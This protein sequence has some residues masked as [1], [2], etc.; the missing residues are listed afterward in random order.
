MTSALKFSCADFT[1]PLLSH[2]DALDLIAKLGIPA[3]D[4]GL[5]PERSHLQPKHFVGNVSAAAKRLKSKVH[6][7]GLQIV[8]LFAVP[9]SI[10]HELAPNHPEEKQR[11]EWRNFFQQVIDLAEE[12]GVRHVTTGPG[13][14]FDG[15]SIAESLKRASDEL[16]WCAE[17]AMKAGRQL[18]V[19]AH[20]WSVASTPLLARKLVEMTNH[21]TLTLDYGHFT[22]Q[23]FSDDEIE[24][25]VAYASHFHARSA[26]CDFLQTTLANNTIDFVRVLGAMKE[27][28]YSGYV[29]LEYV[30]ME[31]AL[32]PD[33][34]NLSETILLR[35]FLEHEW[36]RSR[37]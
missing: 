30:R 16:A 29:S 28:D 26:C 18:A 19:E 35:D 10:A 7:R 2:E 25:L 36:N 8:D 34:D 23:G 24:P 22:T 6:D 9:S 4:I 1:F 21:L 17:Q 31:H 12:C 11:Q 3:V 14:H 20:I 37:G 15:E 5:F 13:V 32:V 33:V 27:C